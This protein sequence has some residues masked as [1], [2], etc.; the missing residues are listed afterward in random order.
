[1][2][3]TLDF[4]SCC[5]IR[6]YFQIPTSLLPAYGN[7]NDV[8]FYTGPPTA[9]VDGTIMHPN[10]C[11]YISQNRGPKQGCLLCVGSVFNYKS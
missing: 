1:M 10:Q 9:D 8:Y 7:V 6:L 3:E 4:I 2:F 11:Y 5:G